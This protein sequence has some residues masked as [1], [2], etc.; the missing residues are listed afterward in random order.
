MM[1]L[2]EEVLIENFEDDD[3]GE[4]TK[5][6]PEEPAEGDGA[7]APGLVEEDDDEEEL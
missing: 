3:P 4:E 2:K 6:T 5:V 1:E 7:E